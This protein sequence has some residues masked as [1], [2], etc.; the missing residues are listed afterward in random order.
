MSGVII[1]SPSS[2]SFYPTNNSCNPNKDI[3]YNKTSAFRINSGL[4][5]NEEVCDV[6]VKLT[7]SSSTGASIKLSG[8][9]SCGNTVDIRGYCG[10]IQCNQYVL[11]CRSEL[12]K[13]LSWK[14]VNLLIIYYETRNETTADAFTLSIAPTGVTVGSNAEKSFIGKLAQWAIILMIVGALVML[15]CAVGIPLLFW[16]SCSKRRSSRNEEPQ[17]LYVNPGVVHSPYS[18]YY[19]QPAVRY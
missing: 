8:S 17:V 9:I 14:K 1:H 12:P 2:W 7:D 4:P 18:G 5:K 13:E 15:L 11:Q 10:S 19:G 3:H 6:I 16:R